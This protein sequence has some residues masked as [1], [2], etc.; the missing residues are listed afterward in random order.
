MYSAADVTYNT[1]SFPALVKTL[2][3]LLVPGPPLLLAYKQRD[4]GE[5]DLWRLLKAEGVFM[6]LIDN[7]PGSEDY[8]EVEIWVGRYAG[9]DA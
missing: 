6:D 3:N 9:S 7:I 4:E 1:A 5:K 2:K 8:G